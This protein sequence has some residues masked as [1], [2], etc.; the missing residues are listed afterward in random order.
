MV[1]GDPIEPIPGTLGN[2]DGAD[3]GKLTC[4]KVPNP[5]DEQVSGRGSSISRH[6]HPHAPT[7]A[8][9]PFSAIR[10][11][12]PCAFTQPPPRFRA[13]AQ[14]HL[15]QVE[16]LMERYTDALTRLFDQYKAQAGYPDAVLEIK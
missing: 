14:N 15:T 5:T 1:M 11:C 8:Y 13:R 9:T 16:E 6:A 2:I 3:G 12:V 4:T 7:R 10:T